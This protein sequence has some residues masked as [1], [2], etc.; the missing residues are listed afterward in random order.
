VAVKTIT[1]I[2]CGFVGSITVHELV[3]R[4]FA[5]HWQYRLRLV[6]SD[7]F[8]ARNAA[9]QQATPWDSGKPKVGVLAEFA[10]A[11]NCDVETHHTLV[12]EDNV[13]ELL[14]DSIVVVDAVD[15][16]PTRH[17]LYNAGLKL[18]IPVLHVGIDREGAGRVE[19]SHGGYDWWSLSPH[20][21]AGRKVWKPQSGEKPPCEL[22]AMRGV[23]LNIGLA[24]AKAIGIYLDFDPEA[25]V[26][27]DLSQGTFTAWRATPWEH[28]LITEATSRVE[29]REAQK[30]AGEPAVV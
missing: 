27:K 20:R 6:D 8:E 3:R 9:N 7:V 24:T 22:V 19:W 5:D 12:T 17:M 10:G 16:L 30:V 25:E 4:M 13:D 29:E 23:G 2:G 1:V 14:A 11:F 15:N 21:T 18:S 26:D 28:S